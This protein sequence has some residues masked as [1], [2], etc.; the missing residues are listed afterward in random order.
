MTVDELADSLATSDRQMIRS[1]SMRF[2]VKDLQQGT[3][4]LERIVEDHS[5]YL[6]GST[7]D[8]HVE[9]QTLQ[10]ISADSNEERTSYT[11]EADLRFRVPATDLDSILRAIS[12]QADILDHREVL[13]EDASIPVLST[14]LSAQR[15]AESATSIEHLYDKGQAKLKDVIPAH[16]IKAEEKEKSESDA[17]REL[18][19]RDQIA[20][21]DVHLQVYQRKAVQIEHLAIN[22]P[23]PPYEP[24]FG[25][26]LAESF[27]DGLHFIP[28][29]VLVLARFW[30]P[31]LLISGIIFIISRR[32]TRQPTTDNR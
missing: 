21:S 5:G 6:L 14:R 13:A 24:P 7:L 9:E 20:Y 18:T 3:A 11:L 1:A 10:R 12:A 2:R 17:I 31:L 25:H 30:L 23:A 27:I 28:E 15:H 26:K 22:I 16:R 29:L 19:L 4:A 32:T 8:R